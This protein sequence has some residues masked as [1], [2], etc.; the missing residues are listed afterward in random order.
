MVGLE[1]PVVLTLDLYANISAAMAQHNTA[2]V[3]YRANPHLDQE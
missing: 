2:L 3:T 1:M